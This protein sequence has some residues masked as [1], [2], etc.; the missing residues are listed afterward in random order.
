[1]SSVKIVIGFYAA[2]CTAVFALPFFAGGGGSA[3]P[4]GPYACGPVGVILDTI[5]TVETGGNYQTTI[6]SASAS[7]AYAFIDVAWR[8]YAALAGVDI[9]TYPRA[10]MATETDQDATASVYVNEILDRYDGDTTII[11]LAWYLP[12]S[13]GNPEQM[14]RVPAMGANTLTPREYQTKWMRVYDEKLAQHGG[15]LNARLRRR[16]RRRTAAPSAPTAAGPSPHPAKRSTPD[17]STTR[18]TT[19]PPGITSPPKAPRS[20]PSP[21]APS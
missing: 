14:D 21:T 4:L 18:T 16:R 17:R 20:T 13:I 5:R 19:I 6:T 15:D 3:G 1:M 11:P 12:S 10:Y 8:H 7:G 9:T 2:L